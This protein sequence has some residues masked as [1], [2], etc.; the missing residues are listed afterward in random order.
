MVPKVVTR[1][2]AAVSLNAV[3][4]SPKSLLPATTMLPSER[5]TIPLA[6]S[7]PVRGFHSKTPFLPNVVSS[8]PAE[9]RRA[10]KYSDSLAEDLFVKAWPQTRIFPSGWIS[11]S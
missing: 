7:R 6:D 11:T 2:P 5:R 9:V 1:A 4:P 10:T 8:A 3:N